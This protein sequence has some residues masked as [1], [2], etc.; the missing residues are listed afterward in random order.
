MRNLL[1]KFT[2]SNVDGCIIYMHSGCHDCS[3]YSV[4]DIVSQDYMSSY[5]K[6]SNRFVSDYAMLTS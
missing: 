4:S 6:L 3:E 2:V 1:F 5:I